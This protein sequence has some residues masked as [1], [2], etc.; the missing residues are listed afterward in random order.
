MGL[1]VNATSRP[2]FTRGKDSVPIVQEPGWA[3]E[4]VWTGAENLARTG[5]RSPYRPA[6]ASRYTDWAIPAHLS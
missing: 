3:P 6:V 5:I 1:L 2:L 4:P